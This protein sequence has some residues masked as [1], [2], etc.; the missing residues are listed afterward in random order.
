MKAFEDDINKK[1][2]TG[3]LKVHVVFFPVSR[4]KLI[5]GLNEGIGD[6][7]CAN[8]TITTDRKKVVDFT[9]PTL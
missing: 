6:I 2:N 7:A 5:S 3:N 1:F 8:L 4:D 9:T